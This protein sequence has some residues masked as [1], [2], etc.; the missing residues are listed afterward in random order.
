M[1]LLG[2]LLR[3]R[4]GVIAIGGHRG[5][6]ENLLQPSP[7]EVYGRVEPAYRENTLASFKQ[8]V[9]LGVSFVEF[10]VQVTRDGVPVLWHDDQIITQA[11]GQPA[12]VSEVKDR[13]MSEFRALVQ[14][15]S[16]SS[17]TQ[18]VRLFRNRETRARIPSLTAW[19][20]QQ[21]DFLPT[22]KE[23][24]QVLP[25]SIGF[26]IEIKM[27][28]PNHIHSTS[29][30]EVDRVVLPVVECVEACA[31]GGDRTI[32]YS[33]FD[34]DVCVKLAQYQSRYQVMFLSGC[35]IYPHVDPRRVSVP[36]AINFAEEH[37]LAGIVLPASILMANEDLVLETSAKGLKVCTYG[38][39]NNC[40]LAVEKQRLLG[41][42]A[43]I[44]DDVSGVC[45]SLASGSDNEW[46]DDLDDLSNSRSNSRSELSSW[47]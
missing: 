41:V 11:P 23:M 18:L 12:V 36:A 20:C 30:E 32:V 15:P 26:D 38:L 7:S 16:T 13:S 21:D 39:E 22:L 19:R 24:F 42:H 6:G 5:C 10:D 31:Q 40:V 34:P 3:P 1:K 17:D 4:P 37:N 43:A 2:Q 46:S 47:N 35:G 29:P 28:V 33:S 45:S 8:A 44:V 27:T 14:Q 25:E 9:A